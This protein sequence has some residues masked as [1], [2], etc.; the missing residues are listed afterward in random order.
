MCVVSNDR[1]YVMNYGDLRTYVTTETF[2][3]DE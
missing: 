1:S 3:L 2:A